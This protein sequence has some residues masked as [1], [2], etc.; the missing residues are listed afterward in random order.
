MRRDERLME[1][2]GTR[3]IRPAA[4][5]DKKTQKKKEGGMASFEAGDNS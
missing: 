5:D 2:G 4:G 3:A 1:S